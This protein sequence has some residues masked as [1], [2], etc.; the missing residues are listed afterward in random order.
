VH[1]DFNVG[2][3]KLTSLEGAPKEVGGDFYCEGNLVDF[4]EEDVRAICNVKGEVYY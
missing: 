1:G 2:Y 4:T 3:N